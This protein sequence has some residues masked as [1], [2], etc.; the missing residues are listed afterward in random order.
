MKMLSLRGLDKGKSLE[1][2]KADERKKKEAMA[3]H[4][5]KA[6]CVQIR[7]EIEDLI[8]LRIVE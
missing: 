1:E 5:R 8:D 6:E 3:E 2:H 7:N 4:K